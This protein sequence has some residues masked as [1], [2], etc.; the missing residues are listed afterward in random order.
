VLWEASLPAKTYDLVDVTKAYKGELREFFLDL[1]RWKRFK[2]R[3]KLSWQKTRFNAVSRASVAR[4]RGIYVFTI[5]LSP[6]KLPAHGYIMY[7]GITGA[8]PSAET[9]YSRYGRYL[10][11]LR[12]G[13][14]RPAILFMLNNWRDDLFFNFVPLPNRAVDLR[15]LEKAFIGAIVPP[16]NKSDLEATI[17]KAKAAAF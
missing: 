11:D 12:T 9:L 16:M 17:R 4:E 10:A 13:E 15:K 14:G 2:S 1:K 5:E 6:S 8:G 7:V 3:Y